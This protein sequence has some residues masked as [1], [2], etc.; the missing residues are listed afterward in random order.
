MLAT[1]AAD[2]SVPVVYVNQVGGQDELVFD[3]ASLVFDA[4]GSLV[5]RAPQFVEDVLVVDLD[6]DPVFRKRTLDPRG[7][8]QRRRRCPKVALSQQIR[9]L[10]TRS[11]PSI[12]PGARPR[13]TRSTRRSSSAR[14]TTSARTGSPT[15]SSGCPAASTRRSSRAIAADALGPE[16]VHG[17]LDAVALLERRLASPTREELADN[18]GIDLRTIADRAGPRRVRSTCSR[19]RSTGASPTSPRRTCR[20][21]SAASLLMAL[22]NKFG[23]LVLTT[24]NKSE[25]AVGYSTLYGDTAGGFAVIKDVP[26]TARSTGSASTATRIGPRR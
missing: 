22:S 17:V 21:A 15:S 4:D 3:G 13:R 6:V 20:A 11:R 2:A 18:L 26:K 10:A 19:R 12:A 25:M 14:A 24:G 16:H 9:S 7:W 8:L 5:A 1:R 23:W